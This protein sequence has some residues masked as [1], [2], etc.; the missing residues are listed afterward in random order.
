MGRTPGTMDRLL[1]GLVLVAL[2]A[3]CAEAVN[4]KG[5]KG[6]S[7]FDQALLNPN[8]ELPEG[9]KAEDKEYTIQ[10]TLRSYPKSDNCMGQTATASGSRYK[11]CKG[12]PSIEECP[13]DVWV[14]AFKC[15]S[16]MNQEKEK[17]SFK[18]KDVTVFWTVFNDQF[19]LRIATK[20]DPNK[21]I[22]EGKMFGGDHLPVCLSWKWDIR[23]V[24][25]SERVNAESCTAATPLGTDLEELGEGA[26]TS[27]PDQ[28]SE[29][30]IHIDG[31]FTFQE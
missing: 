20:A 14:K 24:I 28:V 7:S 16:C 19:Y 6:P 15:S 10:G 22:S 13:N 30:Y 4:I 5:G 8:A 12:A 11:V 18:E 26:T 9:Q 1:V 27:S 3:T 31:S 2:A 17:C 21:H 25:L 29:D 23:N